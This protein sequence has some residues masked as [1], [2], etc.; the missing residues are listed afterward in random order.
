[1]GKQTIPQAPRPE[2]ISV[3]EA[4]E[5]LGCTDV[6]VLKLVKSGSLKGFRLSGRAWAVSRIAVEENLAKYLKR[7]PSQAGRP[8]AKLG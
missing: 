4:A 3:P 6:W 5:M 2:W 1:M 7:D 8:R